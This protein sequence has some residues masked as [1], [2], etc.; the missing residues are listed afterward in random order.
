MS[1]LMGQLF[2]DS[3][4]LVWPLVSLSIFFVTFALIVVATYRRKAGDIAT[5]SALP[6]AD[7]EQGQD[8]S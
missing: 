6:L 5:I 3:P 8:D 1:R 7:D 4:L 2:Q